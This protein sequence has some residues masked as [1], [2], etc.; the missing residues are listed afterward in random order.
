MHLWI[1]NPTQQHP[2]EVD[3]LFRLV[4]YQNQFSSALMMMMIIDD[5]HDDG[6]DDDNDDDG[7]MMQYEGQFRSNKLGQNYS[8]VCFT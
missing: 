6:D 2:Q 1:D 8:I 5:G 4:G 3:N 7:K